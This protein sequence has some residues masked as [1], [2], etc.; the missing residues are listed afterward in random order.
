MGESGP[1]AERIEKGEGIS[2][3]TSSKSLWAIVVKKQVKVQYLY[4]GS[5]FAI[6]RLTRKV[7]WYSIV[8]VATCF[9]E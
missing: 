7:G 8:L 4:L 2:V 5:A 6:A 1:G 3:V 9:L